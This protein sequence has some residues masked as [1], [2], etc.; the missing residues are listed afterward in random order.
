MTARVPQ[1]ADAASRP[2][3]LGVDPAAAKERLVLQ[4]MIRVLQGHQGLSLR[5]AESDLQCDVFFVPADRETR[6]SGHCIRVRLLPPGTED[7]GPGLSLVLPLKVSALTVLLHSAADILASREGGPLITAT[8]RVASRATRPAP[9]APAATRPAPLQGP[10]QPVPLTAAEPPVRAPAA[11]VAAAAPAPVPVR[12]AVPQERVFIPDGP[13]PVRPEA[14]AASGWDLD[15]SGVHGLFRYL[16]TGLMAHE[17]RSV[18]V[19][20]GSGAVPLL[21]DFSTQRVHCR[22]PI[23]ALLRDR[24]Q[25][26]EPRRATQAEVDAMRGEASIRL[27]D[28]LWAAALCLGLSG[29]PALPLRGRYRLLRWPDAAALSH[30]G[31]PRWAALLT[32]YPLEVADAARGS[33]LDESTV[34]WLLEASI[35]LGIAVP[36]DDLDLELPIEPDDGFTGGAPSRPLPLPPEAEAAG[37][38]PNGL[39]HKLRGRLKLW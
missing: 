24:H 35:A 27:Q 14:P 22:D 23:A 7:P 5:F 26:D 29:A 9:L 8:R 19:E 16:T 17:R 37:D 32:A 20:R 18:W 30:P 38:D 13:A 1:A 4:S 12:S 28:L 2:L 33:D 6:V 39:F 31:V 36:V 34:R 3:V 25:V 10:T 21:I 15:M 11:G